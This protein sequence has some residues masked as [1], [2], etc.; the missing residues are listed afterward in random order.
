[1]H[2]GST[3][4][5]ISIFLKFVIQVFQMDSLTQTL[6]ATRVETYATQLSASKVSVVEIP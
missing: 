2:T 4:S 5:S 1:M 3:T 6:K